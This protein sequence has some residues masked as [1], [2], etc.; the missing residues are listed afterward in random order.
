MTLNTFTA[1]SGRH[2]CCSHL[3]FSTNNRASPDPIEIDPDGDLRL[4]VGED[5]VPFVVCAK[6]LARSAR[7]WRTML[8][9]P[10]KESKRPEEGQ[11]LWTVELPEDDPAAFEVVLH[12]VHAQPHKIPKMTVNLAFEVTVVT[13]K[14]GMTSCLWAV[15]KEWLEELPKSWACECAEGRAQLGRPYY[16]GK[17]PGPAECPLPPLEWLW[18]TQEL[19]DL[20]RYQAT[21]RDFA[22]QTDEFDSTSP[23]GLVIYDIMRD[24]AS[25]PL[26]EDD[27]CFSRSANIIRPQFVCDSL[28]KHWKSS[29]ILDFETDLV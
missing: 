13:N 28:G 7:V 10:F 20:H 2:T 19:G 24:E 21:L 22:L 18:I 23:G 5:K 9:G 3:P 8:F 16:T 4:L 29:T 27:S 1:A 26:V 11:G 17:E 25:P 12:L 14:Y 15:S 6:T